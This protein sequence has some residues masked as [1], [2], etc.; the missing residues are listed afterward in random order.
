MSQ[1]VFL[2]TALGAVLLALGFIVLPLRGRQSRALLIG[3]VL[4]VPL[5]ALGLYLSIG[6]PSA[7]DPDTGEAG[8]IRSALGDLAGRALEEPDQAEHWTRLGLAYKRLEEFDSAEHAF[9]RALYIDENS[10]FLRAELAETLLFAS[11]QPE[12]PDEARQLLLTAVEDEPNQKALWLLGLDAFQRGD[13]PIAIERLDTL[14][15]TLEPGSSVRATVDDYLARAKS[16]SGLVSEPADALEGPLL[17]LEIS[18][19]EALAQ[20]LDGSEVLYVVVREANGPNVPL[21]V[22]RL[23]AGDLPVTVTIDESDAMMAGRGIGSVEAVIVTARV[24]FSGDAR[25]A[26]GDLEGRSAILPIRDNMQAEVHIDQ[27]L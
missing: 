21:A 10:N 19:D 6:T 8:Q 24:S 5:A 7:I 18:I 4:A 9:R 15:S 25:A 17:Q 26:D 22:R 3:L 27:V 14:A 12:L 20:R 23:Q 13:W 1:P 11:G 16:H 2:F